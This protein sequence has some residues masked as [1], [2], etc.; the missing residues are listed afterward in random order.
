MTTVYATHFTGR[1][2]AIPANT[3]NADDIAR[4][5]AYLGGSASIVRNDEHVVTYQLVNGQMFVTHGT[6]TKAVN[7]GQLVEV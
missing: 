6:D 2:E 4:G 3:L 7:Y 1:F 5:V